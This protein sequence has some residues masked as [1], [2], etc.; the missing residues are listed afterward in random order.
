MEFFPFLRKKKKIG[1]ALSGGGM[2]GVAHIAVLKALDDYNLKPNIISGTS[3]GAIVG[4]FYALGKTPD[5]MMEI[6]RT[7]QFFSRSSFRINRK[8]IFNP[9]FL[10]KIFKEYFPE[11]NFRCLK[12]PLYAASTE[13]TEGRIE[14][15]SEGPLFQVLLATSAVPFVFP[16]VIMNGKFY[17]DGG[18]LNNMPTEPIRN[19]CDFLIGSHVN[20]MGK[21]TLKN[22]NI[23][24]EFDRILHLAIAGSVYIKSNTCDIFI[25]PP[26]M[27]KYSLFKKES[28]DIVFETVYRYTSEKLENLGYRKL[29][30]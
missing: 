18:V 26:D 2:R 22:M 25:N 17:V 4:A 12:L 3:A 21:E 1:I 29:K 8:G 16:P 6:V 9:D 7:R 28:A 10:L 19:Q 11:D 20:A 13:L 5:E 15:F 27:L 23:S 14:Y 30:Y 24:T